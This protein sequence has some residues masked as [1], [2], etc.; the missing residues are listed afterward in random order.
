MITLSPDFICRS[1]WVIYFSPSPAIFGKAETKLF[2]SAPW[3]PAHIR[4]LALPAAASPSA[5]IEPAAISPSKQ[6]IFKRLL[7]MV[8]PVPQYCK[9]AA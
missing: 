9:L 2:P 5:K 1:C 4:V 7:I 6:I 3:H 8:N